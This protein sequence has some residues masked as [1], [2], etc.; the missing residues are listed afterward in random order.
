M[1]KRML[2]EHSSTRTQINLPSSCCKARKLYDVQRQLPM[3]RCQVADL[4]DNVIM[5]LLGAGVHQHTTIP[6][7]AAWRKPAC[8]KDGRTVSVSRVLCILISGTA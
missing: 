5:L 4:S 1:L 6:L 3:L 2:Q 8:V 7:L